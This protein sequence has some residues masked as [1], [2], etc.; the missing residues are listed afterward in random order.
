M[1]SAGNRVGLRLAGPRLSRGREGELRSEG[2]VLGAI[3]VPPDGQPVLFLNDHPTTG[4]YPVIGCV[5]PGDLPAAGQ[6][7]PGTALRFRPIRPWLGEPGPAVPDATG[8]IMEPVTGPPV[9]TVRMNGS[10]QL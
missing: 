8:R 1:T 4:G 3:Q 9:A 10:G 6:A 7:R 5:H 2:M